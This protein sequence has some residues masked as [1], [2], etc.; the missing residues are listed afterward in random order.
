ML[1]KAWKRFTTW[2]SRVS[3]DV[4][5]VEGDSTL[6]TLSAL[7]DISGVDG[8]PTIGA[9]RVSGDVSGVDGEIGVDMIDS[10]IVLVVVI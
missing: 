9:L 8:D 5:G 7:G 3:E 1:S 6:G 4:S 10:K 2:N